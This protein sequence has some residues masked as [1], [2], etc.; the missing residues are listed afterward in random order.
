MAHK[1][2]ELRLHQFRVAGDPPTS[3]LIAKEMIKAKLQNSRVM[4]RRNHP[5]APSAA[6]EATK[7][8]TPMVT[9]ADSFGT[10]LG[11]EGA[12]ARVYE[13]FLP[14]IADSA[15]LTLFN[16]SEL[17]EKDF[18]RRGGAVSLTQDGRKTVIGTFDRRM[19][20]LLTHPLFKYS[21]SYRRIM[22]MQA[23]LLGRHLLGELQRYPG[24]ATK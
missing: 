7:R 18:I 17:K 6:L 4:L 24:F 22:E 1:N 11:I 9:T 13:E 20:T 14:L 23:R 5:E 10:L 15:A 3:L 21:I 16:N 12:A 2:V 19:D 8:F